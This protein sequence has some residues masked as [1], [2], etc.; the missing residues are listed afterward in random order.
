MA[1]HPHPNLEGGNHPQN[2]LG[3]GAVDPIP[4]LQAEMEMY[5][6]QIEAIR[7]TLEEMQNPPE[8]EE[9]R[10]LSSYQNPA[11][12]ETI[13]QIW[14]PM[15]GDDFELKLNIIGLINFHFHGLASEDPFLHLEDLT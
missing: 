12:T 3:G 2:P 5:N 11:A 9:P 8:R 4:R 15:G 6:E 10:S 13:E 7:E 1:I 14:V